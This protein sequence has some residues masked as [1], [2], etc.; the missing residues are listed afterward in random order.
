[1]TPEQIADELIDEILS[2]GVDR[3]IIIRS[4]ERALKDQRV[5]CAESVKDCEP[6]EVKTRIRLHEAVGACLLAVEI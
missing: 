3:T 2:F 6:V 1:M 4:F 5:L